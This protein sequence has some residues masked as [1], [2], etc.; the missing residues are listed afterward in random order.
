MTGDSAE[1]YLRTSGFSTLGVAT[2]NAIHSTNVQVPG[3]VPP[4]QY[5]MVI[6]ANGIASNP[7]NVQ[8]ST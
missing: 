8:V 2:G 6:I 5:Q 4:G 1:H 3:N 7:V